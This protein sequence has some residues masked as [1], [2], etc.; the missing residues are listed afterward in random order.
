MPLVSLSAKPA[1]EDLQALVAL[2]DIAQVVVRESLIVETVPDQVAVRGQQPE[3]LRSRGQF[4]EPAQGLEKAH[5]HGHVG[6][7]ELAQLCEHR[8]EDALETDEAYQQPG[9][10][11]VPPSREFDSFA[12]SSGL[13]GCD[14]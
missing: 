10:P 4:R 1:H 6:V 7:G 12:R 9:Q 8:L 11:I 5:R 14:Q 13:T 2:P 3:P